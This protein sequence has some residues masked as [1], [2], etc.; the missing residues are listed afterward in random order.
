MPCYG[1]CTGRRDQLRAGHGQPARLA[2]TAA[3]LRLAGARSQV[4]P[5][6]ALAFTYRDLAAARAYAQANL[7][8]HGIPSLGIAVTESG[9]AIG[10]L[11]L[12]APFAR[13]DGWTPAD[14]AWPDTWRYGQP[15][16][17]AG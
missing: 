10:V 3:A 16:P 9:T 12:R 17:Q 15:E 6:D 14:P 5:A 7:D 8:G 2:D 11:D 4:H 13:H 1:D